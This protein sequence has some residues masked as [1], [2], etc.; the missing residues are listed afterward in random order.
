MKP[1]L[2]QFQIETASCHAFT[3]RENTLFPRGWTRNFKLERELLENP[4]RNNRSVWSRCLL[5]CAVMFAS[6]W[7]GATHGEEGVINNWRDAI[8]RVVK[9]TGAGGLQGLQPYQTGILISPSGHVLTALSY[10][11]DTDEISVTLDDGRRFYA[12]LIGAEVRREIA[13]LKIDAD[14]LPHFDLNQIVSNVPAGTRVFA[15]SNL[16]QVAVGSEPVSVQRGVISIQTKLSAR[17]GAAETRFDA[18]VYLLDAITN[19]PGAAGGAVVTRDGRLVAML[20]KEFRSAVHHTWLNYA[21]GIDQ[22][23]PSIKPI[24]TGKKMAN[25]EK[26][27][28]P[29]PES[30]L[31]AAILGVELVPN[32]L[33]RTPPFIDRVRP[34]SPAAAAGLRPNDLIVLIDDRLIQTVDRFCETLERYESTARPAITVERDG[35]LIDLK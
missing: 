17:R 9:I 7:T 18:P 30:P 10:V 22:L 33:D 1:F 21:L 15:L 12:R 25:A 6:F 5:V 32:V 29:R 20:G 13:V 35:K 2:Y 27:E 24:L 16:F 28:P 23:R 11:L 19:N 14:D 34:D 3:L 4:N 26:E 8:P 31:T